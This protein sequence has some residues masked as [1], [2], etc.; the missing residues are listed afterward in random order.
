VTPLTKRDASAGDGN[1]TRTSLT[2][3]FIQQI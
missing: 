1:S 3:S 2:R